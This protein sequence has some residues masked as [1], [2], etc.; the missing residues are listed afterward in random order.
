MAEPDLQQPPDEG[1]TV[2]LICRR[3]IA[4]GA[5]ACF[6]AWTEPDQVMHWFGPPGVACSAAEI[7]LRVGGRWR[8]ATEHPDGS[9]LWIGGDFELIEPPRRL[10]YNW[11]HEAADDGQGPPPET[12]K[13][14][15]RFE[16]RATGTEVIVVHERFGGE[17]AR[18]AHLL[19]WEGCLIEIA[20][21][22]E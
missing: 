5:E 22:L 14:S 1:A 16:P 17:A 20:A 11:A 21:L 18:D 7:D 12:T 8:V 13:V 2:A 15:V 9:T 19:G 10:V 4:A 3:E 6:S